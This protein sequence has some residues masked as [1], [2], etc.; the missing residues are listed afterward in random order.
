MRLKNVLTSV[1]SVALVLAPQITQAQQTQNRA[2]AKYLA[3]INHF[4]G[5]IKSH[6]A[7]RINAT[8]PTVKKLEYGYRVCEALDQGMTLDDV[9]DS[10]FINAMNYSDSGVEAQ[11]SYGIAIQSSAI[12]NL[13]P[14]YNDGLAIPH[15]KSE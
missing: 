4:L 11:M 8:T 14:K 1:L 6:G 9:T 2:E 13:C 7:F 15:Q 12:F 5:K 3:G 10:A